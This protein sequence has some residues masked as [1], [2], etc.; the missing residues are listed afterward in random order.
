MHGW[1][2]F[3]LE[4]E[5][6]SYIE[7]IWSQIKGKIKEIYYFIPGKKFILFVREVEYKIKTL[8]LNNTEKIANFFSCFKT[9]K[10]VD[11]KYY[12]N[13]DGQFLNLFF[14]NNNND[15]SNDSNEDS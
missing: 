11:E 8:S 2:D 15:D 7:S 12:D 1:G 6:T 3:E 10:N 13:V 9:V 4:L 14:N 5:S